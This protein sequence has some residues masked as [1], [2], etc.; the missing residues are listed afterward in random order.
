MTDLTAIVGAITEAPKDTRSLGKRTKATFSV[1]L[2]TGD[3]VSPATLAE[4]LA[5]AVGDSER[6]E[7]RIRVAPEETR[8]VDEKRN[9]IPH[10]FTFSVSNGVRVKSEGEAFYRTL[11]DELQRFGLKPTRAKLD[12]VTQGWTLVS[13]VRLHD[14]DDSVSES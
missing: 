12:K 1:R 3:I 11:R 4:A 10:A 13:L 6:L 5:D 8:S 7:L 9:G 2:G 14:D